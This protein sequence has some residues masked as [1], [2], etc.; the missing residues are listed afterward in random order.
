MVAL[1][2]FATVLSGCGEHKGASDW[3]LA[4]ADLSSTRALPGSGINR[5]NA[6]SLH[7]A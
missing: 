6:H 5:Q 1:A 4:N 3:P 2:A 7:V